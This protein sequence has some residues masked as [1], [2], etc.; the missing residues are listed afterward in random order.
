MSEWSQGKAHSGRALNV[1]KAQGG[2]KRICAA[3][4]EPEVD[5]IAN[6][7]EENSNALRVTRLTDELI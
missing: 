5:L 2:K 7:H 4:R 6:R 1:V 3:D